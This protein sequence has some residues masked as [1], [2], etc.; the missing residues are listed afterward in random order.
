M[1]ATIELINI[2][3]TSYIYIYVCVCVGVCV[4]TSH[5]RV[6]SLTSVVSNSLQP[7]E[8]KSTMLFCP[9]NFPCKD[10]GLS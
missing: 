4:Y 9:W 3:I 5:M 10:T 2:S 1:I 7:C 8:L 6:Y